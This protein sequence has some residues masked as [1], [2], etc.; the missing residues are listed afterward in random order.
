[1]GVFTITYNATA[2]AAGNAP[3]L[4]N[5]TVNV[6]DTTAPR[7]MVDPTNTTLQIGDTFTLP[8]VNLT[9]NDP[10]YSGIISNSTTPSMVDTSSVGVFTITYNGTADASGNAYLLPVVYNCKCN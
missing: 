1:M 6:T 7:I 8:T 10:A 4:V 5:V 9:D 3:L 2:D